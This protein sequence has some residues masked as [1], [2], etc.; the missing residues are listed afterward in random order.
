[1]TE[2]EAQQAQTIELCK[3]CDEPTGKAG[4]NEDS[5]YAFDI[6]TGKID[7]PYCEECWMHLDEEA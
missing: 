2:Q 4:K 7:G 3:Q 6:S 5:L 1:M